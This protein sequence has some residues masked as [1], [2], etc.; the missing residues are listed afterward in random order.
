MV[1]LILELG[2]N[3]GLADGRYLYWHN[4][5]HQALVRCPVKPPELM[6]VIMLVCNEELYLCQALIRIVP[7]L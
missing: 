4:R 3:E 5:W 1:V 7:E 6:S 2:E